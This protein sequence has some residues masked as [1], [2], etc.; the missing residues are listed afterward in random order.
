MRAGLEP[1]SEAGP[2]C[3]SGPD[4]QR[5]ADIDDAVRQHSKTHPALHPILGAVA[6]PVQSV[7]ALDDTDAA[8]TTGPPRLCALE[9]ATLLLL[10]ALHALRVAVGNCNSLAP[11]CRTA[12]SSAWE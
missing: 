4:C 10:F 3:S 5:I 8:L 9:P 11:I 7:S 6:A 2:S 12:F 1:R